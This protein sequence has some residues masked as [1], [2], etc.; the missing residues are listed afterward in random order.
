MVHLPL[1]YG[2][3]VA[4][5]DQN[6]RQRSRTVRG[7]FDLSLTWTTLQCHRR[8]QNIVLS[9]SWYLIRVS[10]RLLPTRRL[11]TIVRPKLVVQD[12][13]QGAS[14]A[15]ISATQTVRGSTTNTNNANC[16]C[17]IW[18]VV[19][20]S[21]DIGNLKSTGITLGQSSTTVGHPMPTLPLHNLPASHPGALNS[22]SLTLL[23]DFSLFHHVML[24]QNFDISS[25]W[26]TPLRQA[27]LFLQTRSSILLSPI[28]Q[29]T[30]M[31]GWAANHLHTFELH[32]CTSLVIIF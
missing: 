17:C 24:T 29:S 7:R 22:K 25:R 8:S 14:S 16:Q 31:S 9:R 1:I 23:L 3:L 26:I 18:Y 2:S 5:A 6:L 30:P 21:S 12:I 11:I 19:L 32:P 10:D 13:A 4:V 15:G 20:I 28:Q 27:A